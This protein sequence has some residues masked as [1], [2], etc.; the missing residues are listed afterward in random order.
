[1]RKNQWRRGA[2]FG[3]LQSSPQDV[4]QYPIISIYTKTG[5]QMGMNYREELLTILSKLTRLALRCLRLAAAL[6][7]VA[8][9]HVTKNHIQSVLGVPVMAVICC[10]RFHHGCSAQYRVGWIRTLYRRPLG[11]T[12][13]QQQLSSCAPSI[14]T[15]CVSASS[16]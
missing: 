16:G 7:D 3:S 9:S 8:F 6:P 1:M 2:S 13:T 5:R 15:A 11:S 4:L 12:H 14:N 10:S